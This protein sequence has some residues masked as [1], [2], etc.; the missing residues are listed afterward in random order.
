M[1]I[2]LYLW[3]L[4]P[5]PVHERFAALIDRLSR[6]M[7]TPRFI[8]HITLTGSLHSPYD[9]IVRLTADLAATLAPIPIRL[10]GIGCTD[11]YYRCLFMRAERS[12]EL[13]AAHE[14][15]CVR[16]GRS[17]ES[18]FMPH[19]SLIYGDLPQDRKNSIVQEIGANFDAAFYANRIGLCRLDGSPEQWQLPR[20]FT[21]TGRPQT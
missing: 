9:E 18:D 2:P 14:A 19:L 5:T 6:R 11:Q 3:L 4:P 17:P 16:L 15:A 7:G 12:R 8:P 13:L 20:T 21:L 1:S 10:A